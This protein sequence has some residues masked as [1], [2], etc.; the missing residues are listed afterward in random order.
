MQAVDRGQWTVVS[1]QF[2]WPAVLS[3]CSDDVRATPAETIINEAS[4]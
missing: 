4:L 2:L 3:V 1:G